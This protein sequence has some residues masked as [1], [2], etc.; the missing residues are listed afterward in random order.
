MVGSVT[1]AQPICNANA[2]EVVDFEQPADTVLTTRSP[3]C[4]RRF[5]VQLTGT[6]VIIGAVSA[7]GCLL[8]LSEDGVPNQQELT[9][10][11][12]GPE[13]LLML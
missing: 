8:Q 12:A 2:G 11:E 10:N 3:T 4:S 7:Q 1:L 13:V 9:G 6:T 5:F